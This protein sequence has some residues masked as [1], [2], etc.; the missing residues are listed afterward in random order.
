MRGAI[1]L[2]AHQPTGRD[3]PKIL[4][5]C[6]FFERVSQNQLKHYSKKIFLSRLSRSVPLKNILFPHRCYQPPLL[7]SEKFHDYRIQRSAQP[8][9][10]HEEDPM[11]RIREQQQQQQATNDLN[12]RRVRHLSDYLDNGV[13]SVTV[14]QLRWEKKI[15]NSNND[16]N[17]RGRFHPRV[18][19]GYH[20]APVKLRT[21]AECIDYPTR[22][23]R[24][25]N[26]SW[27][28]T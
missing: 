1:S 11:V 10:S 21:Y 12:R 8:A 6:N 18:Y 19:P 23:L 14:E 28:F 5:Q 9:A 16:K 25:P 2:I 13:V 20:E 26:N 4:F 24:S 3:I 15:Q 27:V 17:T 22:L 7:R